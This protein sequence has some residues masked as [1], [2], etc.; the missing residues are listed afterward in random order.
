MKKIVSLSLLL[1]LLLCVFSISASANAT[2]LSDGSTYEINAE[3]KTATLVTWAGD[4]AAIQVPETITADGVTYTVTAVGSQAVTK[5]AELTS[6][7]LPA[8][9][10]LINGAAFR[11]CTALASITAPGVR[12][13]QQNA[14]GGCNKLTAADLPAL[15]KLGDYVFQ[16]CTNL[17]T[18]NLPAVTEVGG[19]VFKNCAALT[20]VELPAVTFLTDTAFSSATGLQT[21]VFGENLA[22]A[23]G[24]TLFAGC[25]KLS[26]IQFKCTAVP[27]KV[28]KSTFSSLPA[29]TKILVPSGCAQAYK[30]A[31]SR[32]STIIKKIV[33]QATDTAALSGTTLS[34]GNLVIILVILAAAVVAVVVAVIV[35]K[36]KK[37]AG[38]N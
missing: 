35:V 10:T 19:Y 5:K 7:T 11:G 37:P 14:F 34:Q 36:K 17:A 8:S 1:A 30:N 12:E 21:V 15:E 27:A 2:V 9:V 26:T 20:T 25:E 4:P 16:D 3:D 38:N 33:E 28:S 32:D 18:V 6:L 31:V 13:L 23:G 24:S 22:S 29:L